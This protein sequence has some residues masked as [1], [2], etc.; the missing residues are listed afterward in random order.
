MIFNFKIEYPPIA[1]MRARY[2]KKTG[3]HYNVQKKEEAFYKLIIKKQMQKLNISKFLEGPLSIESC[4]YTPIPK[5]ASKKRYLAMIGSPDTRKPDIDNLKK[6]LLDSMNGILYADDASVTHIV[7]SKICSD[8]PRV[9]F[10]VS[11]ASGDIMIN[12]HAKTVKEQITVED[13][14]YMVSKA[15]KLGLSGRHVIR[16]F[17]QEDNEG[18]HYYFECEG[19]TDKKMVDP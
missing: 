19:L 11:V 14:N 18:K 8:R 1:K 15:N 4:F 12:E 3:Q 10:K 7:C 2:S 9:E 13:L 6:F 16:V 5:S 17:M